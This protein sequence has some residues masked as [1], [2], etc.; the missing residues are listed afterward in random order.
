[1]KTTIS[2]LFLLLSTQVLIA[3]NFKER[4]LANEFSQLWLGSIAFADLDG[5]GDEDAVLCG[6][7][8]IGTRLMKQYRNLDGWFFEVKN[9][10]LPGMI[11][12]SLAFSDV[13]KDGDQDLLISGVSN[14]GIASRNTRLY[15]NDG[16]GKLSFDGNAN[17]EGLGDGAIA[18]SDIDGDG[19]E[20]LLI[21]G[22]NNDREPS[23]KLYNNEGGVFTEV[24]NTPFEGVRY[25][26]L[27]F[28]DMDGDEDEDL[29]MEGQTALDS[30]IVKLYVNDGGNF[31][32]VNDTT[33]ATGASSV[34]VSDIDGDGDKDLFI[35]YQY[36]ASKLFFNENGIFNEDSTHFFPKFWEATSAFADMDG[37]GDEDLLIIGQEDQFGNGR[38][39]WRYINEGGTFTVVVDMIL[40]QVSLGDIAFADVDADGDEDLLMTGLNRSNQIITQLYANDGGVLSQVIDQPLEPKGLFAFADV[41]NDGDEDLIISGGDPVQKTCVTQLYINEGGVFLERK[42]SDLINDVCGTIEFIDLDGNGE[43]QMMIY[44]TNNARERVVKLY[45][46]NEGN[47]VEDT[48]NLAGTTRQNIAFSD[49]DGD[50]DQDLLEV[51]II[52]PDPYIKLH[53]YEAGTFTE[54]L[55]VPFEVLE[56]PAIAFSDV[57]GDEDKDILISGRD[58]VGTLRTILYSNDGGIFTEVSDTPFDGVIA[59]ALA[60]SDIDLDGDEDLII[61]G[62]VRSNGSIT[63]L[64]VNEGGQFSEVLNTPFQE[65]DNPTIVFSD[66]DGDGDEDLLTSGRFLLPGNTMRTYF[67]NLYINDEGNFKEFLDTP[68]EEIY[69]QEVGFSDVDGDGDNDLLVRGWDSLNCIIIKYYEN[70]GGEGPPSNI[71]VPADTQLDFVLFPNPTSSSIQLKFDAIE[72]GEIS[73]EVYDLQGTLIQQQQAYA[74]IGQQTFPVEL[75]ALVRGMYFFVLR[76]GKRR[77]VARFL[78]Q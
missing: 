70:R 77:G 48:T 53:T 10:S 60:F 76:Q 4:P 72:T 3:Q 21:T 43:E 64:Y 20:D 55:N 34:A 37:D 58:S 59:G 52:F 45:S 23:S 63:K 56:F 42:D 9:A 17:F 74:V 32:E 41:D 25:S 1:M 44:G 50:G 28:F 49:I 61:S 62:N 68:F 35:S 15:L 33:F 12:S 39:T 65:L 27:V 66:V 8:S 40:E 13:D 75:P 51:G 73:L 5:D 16:K 47:F 38:G 46:I 67:I 6:R 54:V 14:G 19:D 29:L 31:S 18:F 26:S 69:T 71:A 7:D 22:E 24:L 78:R 36:E 2:I 57:D 30:Q 11:N